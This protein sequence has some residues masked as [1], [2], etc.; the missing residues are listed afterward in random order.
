[1][2]LSV[3]IPDGDVASIDSYASEHGI[4]GLRRTSKAQAEPVRS[5]AVERVTGPAGRPPG[6]LLAEL[7]DAMSL[8]L[9]LR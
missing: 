9:G 5:V 8:H 2:T 4:D 7:D 1:M 3:S 6:D